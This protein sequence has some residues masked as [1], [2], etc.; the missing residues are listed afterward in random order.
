M[1]DTADVTTLTDIQW[2]ADGLVPVVVQDHATREV[3][4][5]A[6]ANA[7]A[8]QYTMDT[9]QGTYWSRS[10]QELWTKGLTSGHTQYVR[11]IFYDCDA[12][13]LLYIV[14]QAGAACHT[15]THSC[16]TQRVLLA[17]EPAKPLPDDLRYG[18]E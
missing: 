18:T 1:S 13:T 12:D 5:L 11:A 15:N 4:M 16:F 7:E 3:L 17:D 2:N 14:D 10:R 8:V 9:R 6:W